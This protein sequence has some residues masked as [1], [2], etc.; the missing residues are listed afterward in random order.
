M[1]HTRNDIRGVSVLFR[2][3]LRR[4]TSSE[5]LFIPDLFLAF[6]DRFL[7]RISPCI[8]T[9]F[10]S[11]FRTNWNWREKSSLGKSGIKSG[12][13]HVDAPLKSGIKRIPPIYHS[14]YVPYVSSSSSNGLLLK[15]AIICV[16]ASSV[17]SAWILSPTLTG[18][19]LMEVYKF[20][21]RVSRELFL[22]TLPV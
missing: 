12:S 19:V 9:A 17:F 13:E 2:I 5:S 22:K 11:G 8:E 3:W 15:S 20:N 6:H 10:Y 21:S 14:W 18:S 4:F 16:S 1:E 7:F